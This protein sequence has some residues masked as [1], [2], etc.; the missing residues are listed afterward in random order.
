MLYA[1]VVLGVPVDGPFDYRV[2][3]GLEKAIETG[4]RVGVSFGNQKKIGYVAGLAHK[5]NFKN[6]KEL[7][8]IIDESP[9]LDKALL[10]LT[11]KA[12]LYYC[13]SWGQAIETALPKEIRNGR[14]LLIS[15]QLPQKT[16]CPK[17]AGILLQYFDEK[18]KWDFY[19][20]QLEALE[21]NRS[22]I[23]VMPDIDS[24]QKAQRLIRDR[25]GLDSALL[26]RGQPKEAQIWQSIKNGKARIVIGT[27]SAVFAPVGN[28][29]LLI[30]DDEHNPVYKQE[31]TPHYHARDAGLMRCQIEKAKLILASASP[32]LESFYLAKTKKI[33]YL[34]F[35][36][37]GPYPQ[38][39]VLENRSLVLINKKKNLVFSKYLQDLIFS[40]LQ[41][42]Q[43]TLI[44][45]N[46][47][48]FAT[49]LYCH[50]CGKV[51][52]CSRCNVNLVY[53]FKGKILSCHHCNFKMELPKICPSCNSGYIKYSG[54]GTERLESELSRMF[55]QA[56]IKR[57]EAGQ[58][59]DANEYDLFVGTESI[60]GRVSDK[61]DLVVALFIDNSLNRVDLRAAEKTFAL[62]VG[63]WVLTDKRLIIQSNLSGHHC[64]EALL[65]RDT[66]L[67][68]NKELRQRKQLKFPP[69]RHMILVKL[70]GRKEDKLRGLSL[71]LFEKIKEA[72]TDKGIE[73]IS[74][75]AGQPSKL[76][77]NF[78]WQI[79]ISGNNPIKA[80]SFIKKH[81]KGFRH[82]GIIVTVDV[83]PI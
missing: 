28:L 17:E 1:K 53:H 79:L 65:K 22:A 82:S 70:R 73:V 7:T 60:I 38:V 20:Q 4:E 62:L 61:F 44:F 55:P 5:T 41:S 9:V 21:R 57:I 24:A 64:F 68:Y 25:A 13:C 69:Y 11:K 18:T 34:G 12:S 39:K 52:K 15:R 50:S 37:S 31:Q 71:E 33:E 36:R 75:N 45:L 23:M 3:K 2:P 16:Q 10:L 81:L 32:S 49:F 67:F 56:R 51:L 46:R 40:S 58:R 63:L 77:E 80:N 74:V 48:G 29:G 30:V 66:G 47:R 43:K 14:K 35:P 83:D 6:L 19:F 72:N 42:K 8:Q 78:Y 26:F 54:L 27:R 76:R 59:P